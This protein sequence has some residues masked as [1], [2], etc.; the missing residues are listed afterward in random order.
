M[1]DYCSNE[2]K[3]ID[4][5][6]FR[7]AHRDVSSAAVADMFGVNDSTTIRAV[8]VTPYILRAQPPNKITTFR[9][10]HRSKLCPVGN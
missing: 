6:A 8:M 7:N 10:S 1:A 9:D 5:I 3:L 4:T 2:E